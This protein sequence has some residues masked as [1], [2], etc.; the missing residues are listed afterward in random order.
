MILHC[1]ERSANQFCAAK[2]LTKRCAPWRHLE[3]LKPLPTTWVSLRRKQA[4]R[5]QRAKL[6]RAAFHAANL[7]LRYLGHKRCNG[8]AR[9][10]RSRK[11]TNRVVQAH[12]LA[13]TA[14]PGQEHCVM[15]VCSRHL[16]EARLQAQEHQ[17][18]PAKRQKQRG[19]ARDGARGLLRSRRTTMETPE[20]PRT[21]LEYPP[22][23]DE[24]SQSQRCR[25]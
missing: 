24:M 8:P 6:L 11:L 18:N 19:P 1:L 16:L 7:G 15:L 21:G 4:R 12:L 20:P 5:L 14:R 3:P 2:R 22:S 17:S 10:Q 9:H 25:P 13:A 23:R